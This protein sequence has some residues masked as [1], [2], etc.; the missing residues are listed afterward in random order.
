MMACYGEYERPALWFWDEPKAISS[1]HQ[2]MLEE[3]EEDCQQQPETIQWR[4]IRCGT[5]R[6]RPI[7]KKKSAKASTLFASPAPRRAAV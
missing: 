5:G 3:C 6:K 1:Y 2:R 7:P 4:Y